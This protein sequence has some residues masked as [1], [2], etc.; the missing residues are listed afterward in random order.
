MKTQTTTTILE[1]ICDVS[2]STLRMG[3]QEGEATWG[4]T[5]PSQSEG[6]DKQ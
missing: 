4:N 1:L 3:A 2:L 6:R 5:T